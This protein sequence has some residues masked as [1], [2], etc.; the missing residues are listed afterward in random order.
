MVPD[1][2]DASGQSAAR[3]YD[4]AL[5]ANLRYFPHRVA[6]RRLL[7]LESQKMKFIQARS[8]RSLIYTI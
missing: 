4:R 6:M 3:R 2:L 5:C 8:E 1:K 7:F